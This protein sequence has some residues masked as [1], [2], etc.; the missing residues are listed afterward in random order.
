MPKLASVFASK[1][2]TRALELLL[3]NSSK[4]YSQAGL[5]RDMRCSASTVSRI[6]KPLVEMGFVKMD[7]VGDQMKILA[8]NTENEGTKLLMEFYEKFKKV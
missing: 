3:S 7:K 4:V 1:Q 2:Q 5:A 6:V 8:L